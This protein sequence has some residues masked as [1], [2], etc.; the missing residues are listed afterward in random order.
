MGVLVPDCL[1]ALLLGPERHI[2]QQRVPLLSWRQFNAPFG[3]WVRHEKLLHEFQSRIA[4]VRR[5]LQRRYES[6]LV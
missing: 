1:A 6:T 3:K 5:I 2:A 4:V